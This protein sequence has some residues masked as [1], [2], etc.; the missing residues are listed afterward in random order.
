MYD[1]T[2]GLTG[3]AQTRHPARCSRGYFHPS[4][5]LEVSA[6]IELARKRGC[7]LRVRGAGHSVPAAIASD[8]RL[9]GDPHE[10]IDI[11]LDRLTTV[12]F[13]DG[14]MQVRVGAGCRLGR[15][16]RDPT[17]RSTRENGLCAQLHA[18][19]WALPNLGGISEQT[20]AG[21]FM[22]GSAGG[23]TRHDAHRAIVGL[24][25][26]DGLGRVRALTPAD[27]DAF[28]AAGVSMG[29]LGVVTELTLQCEP[30]F[31]V[32]GAE[33][34]VRF[35]DAPFDPF[36]SGPGSLEGFLRDE[37][38]ARV[39]WWPQRG[40]N[41][42][43]IWR[44]QRMRD[45]DYTAET[46]PKGALRREPFATFHELGA[47]V[48]TQAVGA[49]ALS[50]VAAWRPALARV[51]S[52]RAAERI[53]DVTSLAGLGRVKRSL[54]DEFVPLSREPRCFR[55]AWLDALPMDHAL[56]ERALPMSFCELWFD[57]E[58]TGEIVRRL[59]SLYESMGDA[60][61]GL[62]A[63]ELYAG[64]ATEF[65]LSP[66][67][68]RTSVRVNFYWYNAAPAA[69]DAFLERF[70]TLLSDLAPRFHW[71]KLLPQGAAALARRHTPQWEAFLRERA[72][73]DPEGVFLTRYW[74]A[75]V[76]SEGAPG[77]APLAKRPSIDFVTS[78]R[79]RFPLL[80]ALD[81]VAPAAIEDQPNVFRLSEKFDEPLD[82]MWERIATFRGS[83]E[84]VPFMLHAELL[85]DAWDALHASAIQTFGPGLSAVFQTTERV[86]QARWCST[87]TRASL[88]LVQ[89]V[90][91]RFELTATQ[92]GGTHVTWTF[93]FTVGAR[94]AF[95][96]NVVSTLFRQW[97]RASFRRLARLTGSHSP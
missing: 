65:L 53:A 61:A 74:R 85:T 28:F 43:V 11:E 7:Q 82:R 24:R 33:Q 14:R 87:V 42:F 15:D 93:G 40:I 95:A 19:G 57:I 45:G 62:M 54:Y 48:L 86:P 29:L 77:P 23:S 20:V 75:Q 64:C 59:A 78:R 26:V 81:P 92:D 58:R 60:A 73:F 10:H 38:Y 76:L 27:G 34:V 55:D 16:P 17:A 6:L 72:A 97:F 35:E 9:E 67:Y 37:D 32:C 36:G 56:D 52:P 70:I 47:P 25:V 30:A 91:E 21:F 94:F 5:D 44:A 3:A 18:R 2:S 88:P 41:R 96:N 1:T 63:V 12:A 69:P 71:G 80:F 66:G 84:W 50:A 22:T 31:D 13:D 68:R 46:G 83:T 89:A 49:L 79:F 4:S 90:G 8:G 51:L 39:E